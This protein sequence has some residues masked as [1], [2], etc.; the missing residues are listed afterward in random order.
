MHVTA[1]TFGIT[2]FSTAGAYQNT[3]VWFAGAKVCHRSETHLEYDL[4]EH[5][6]EPLHFTGNIFSSVSWMMVGN[7]KICSLMITAVICNAKFNCSSPTELQCPLV[8]RTETT[9]LAMKLKSIFFFFFI[10]TLLVSL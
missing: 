4:V 7:S 1:N 9:T 2:V 5:V 8:V 3:L 10:Y 6:F